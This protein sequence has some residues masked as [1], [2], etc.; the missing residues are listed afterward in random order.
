MLRFSKALYNE[1]GEQAGALVINYLAKGMLVRFRQLMSQRFDQQGMLLDSQGYWL[2]NHERSNEWGADLG[3]PEHKFG[4]FFPDVW[5]V[6]ESK[7]SGI[8]EGEL[9]VFRYQSVEPLNFRDNQPAH[10]RAEHHP[11]ITE[12]SFTNTNW[13]LVVFIP[14]EVINSR[15]FLNQPLGRA[16]LVLVTLM[17]LGMAF[18]GAFL[19]VQRQLRQEKEQ[20]VLALLELQA[21][22][23]GLTGIRNRNG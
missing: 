21:S 23:D 8:Y 10:F 1:Q 5:P 7:K 17:L 6:I 9:G 4:Q 11:L 19:S 20:Q 16:L 3:R 14:W 22:I 15:S 13:K 2:S 12:E 18:L